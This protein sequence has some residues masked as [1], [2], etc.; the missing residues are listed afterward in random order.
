MKIDV[1]SSFATLAVLADARAMQTVDGARLVRD[2]WRAMSRAAARLLH[3][4]HL[5]VGH[6]T[7]G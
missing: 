3:V 4:R 6:T 2:A 7:V 1:E 5:T